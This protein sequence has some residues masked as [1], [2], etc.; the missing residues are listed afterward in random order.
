MRKILNFVKIAIKNLAC[1]QVDFYATHARAY[2]VKNVQ[3][4][5]MIKS[6][7]HVKVVGKIRKNL[8]AS[9]SNKNTKEMLLILLNR[10]SKK[11]GKYHKKGRMKKARI[12]QGICID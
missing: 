1:V 12:C 11:R 7:G 8:K 2:F 9:N 3:F 5:M 4:K 6:K 10:I